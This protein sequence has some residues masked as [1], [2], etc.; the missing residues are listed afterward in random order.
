MANRTSTAT[1]RT[2]SKGRRHPLATVALIVIG[3]VSTGGAYAL[4]STT[5]SAE[6]QSSATAASQ[7]SIEQGKKLFAAN[8]ATCHG[9]S[10]EGVSGVA[11][12]LYGVGAASVSFQVGTGRMPLANQGPQAEQKPVQFTKEQVAALADY[13]ASLAPGPGIPDSKYL[14]ANGNA[15]TGAELF[16]VNCAMCH[17]VA[18]AGGPSPRASSPPRSAAPRRSTSTRPWSPARRTCRC[19]MTR[20]SRRPRRPTSSRT[21]STS[22]RTP[23]PGGFDLGNLGPVAEGLFIWIFGL[24]AVVGVTIWITAR[25]N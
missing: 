11:P 14:Q 9:L 13:V 8:C 3:L 4:F 16:R 17:N 10:A 25:A 23:R 7:S 22:T 5:A 1:R 18:G 24:G 15:A 20:T 21:S 19:S 6:T 12:S 2:R